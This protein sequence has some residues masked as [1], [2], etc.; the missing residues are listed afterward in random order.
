MKVVQL[1]L[2]YALSKLSAADAQEAGELVYR[3][4]LSQWHKDFPL[5]T[6]EEAADENERQEILGEHEGLL[7]TLDRIIE[8]NIFEVLPAKCAELSKQYQDKKLH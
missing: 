4:I 2:V 1:E 7:A 6:Y 5:D 3:K 8:N